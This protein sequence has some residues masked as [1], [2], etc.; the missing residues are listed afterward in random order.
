MWR[1]NTIDSANQHYYTLSWVIGKNISNKP[2][3]IGLIQNMF[4]NPYIKEGFVLQIK[5]SERDARI[6]KWQCFSVW[7]DWLK[8]LFHRVWGIAFMIDTLYT[9]WFVRSIDQSIL[10]T[11]YRMLNKCILLYVSS[12]QNNLNCF[13]PISIRST[14]GCLVSAHQ[15]WKIDRLVG[16]L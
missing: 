8:K 2:L 16:K 9:R 12:T 11:N 3:I 10:S 5:L 4:I 6:I 13:L 7:F 1:L 14:R 15:I